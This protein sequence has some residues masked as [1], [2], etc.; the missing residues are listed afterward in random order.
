MPS[1]LSRHELSRRPRKLYS[2]SSMKNSQSGKL[3]RGGSDSPRIGSAA[4]YN[5]SSGG[6]NPE[7]S[8]LYRVDSSITNSIG[9]S[10]FQRVESAGEWGHFVDM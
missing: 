3:R 9:S 10:Q 2:Q 7:R 8:P 1:M 6:Y 5:S 4:T